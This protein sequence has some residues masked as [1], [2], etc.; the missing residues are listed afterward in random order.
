MVNNF[1]LCTFSVC[2]S[3]SEIL[4]PSLYHQIAKYDTPPNFFGF[5]VTV[6]IL[7]WIV[8]V[9]DIHVI[10]PIFYTPQ[11]WVLDNFIHA[12]RIAEGARITQGQ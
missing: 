4:D 11:V 10:H 12:Y 2:S 1:K 8:A 5:T 6:A 9:L 7:R 3:P